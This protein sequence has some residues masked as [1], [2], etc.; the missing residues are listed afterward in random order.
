MLVATQLC[1]ENNVYLI[2]DMPTTSQYSRIDYETSVHA[3]TILISNEAGL[4]WGRGRGVVERRENRR[5]ERRR[6]KERERERGEYVHNYD[7]QGK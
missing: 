3:H 2:I 6:G 1:R 4:V 7:S 5:E